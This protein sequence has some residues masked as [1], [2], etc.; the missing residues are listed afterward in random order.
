[1]TPG[2]LFYE[3]LEDGKAIRCL[4]CGLVSHSAIDVRERY[5]GFCDRFHEDR[6]GEVVPRAELWI[7]QAV[8]I[9]RPDLGDAP[10]QAEELVREVV[11]KIS[12]R[13]TPKVGELQWSERF[14]AS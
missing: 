9:M 12:P 14:K 13:G 2:E 8:R 6:A 11:E 1:M 5:C 7:A 4:L 10:L 3:L